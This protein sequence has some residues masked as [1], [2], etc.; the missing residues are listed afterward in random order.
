MIEMVESEIITLK[1]LVLLSSSLLLL[2]YL[3]F[4][5]TGMAE[6]LV[7]GSQVWGTETIEIY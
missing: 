5:L 1:I 2:S 7:K 3:I 6:K 4:G